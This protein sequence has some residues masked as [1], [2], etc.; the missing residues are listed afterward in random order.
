MD[1][2]NRT[3]SKRWKHY[4][5][6]FSYCNS[7]FLNTTVTNFVKKQQNDFPIIF[8][9]FS[10]TCWNIKTI[11]S[12]ENSRDSVP[13]IH[14]FFWELK[15]W[16]CLKLSSVSSGL[17]AILFNKSEI[18][19]V[20]WSLQHSKKKQKVLLN[21]VWIGCSD[22][23]AMAPVLSLFTPMSLSSPRQISQN[24]WAADELS[25]PRQVNTWCIVLGFSHRSNRQP[26]IKLC[27]FFGQA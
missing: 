9:S 7:S 18:N 4:K 2:C 20:M 5:S 14:I 1:I 26:R 16:Q 8:T 6:F 13:K 23:P 25:L 19:E 24:R 17:I 10:Q 11:F 22:W 3:K 15:S 21:T 27:M 12:R